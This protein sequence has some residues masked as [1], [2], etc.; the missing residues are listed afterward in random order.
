MLRLLREPLLHFL[1]LGALLFRAY[2][3][4]HGEARTPAK[5]ILV[6]AGQTQS[7]QAQFKRARNRAPTPEETQALVDG[8]V[9]D[10]ILYR[11]GLALGLDRDDSV[12]RRRVA[13]KLEFIVDGATP[14]SPTEAELQAWLDA[15]SQ[16][17]RIE[18][19][20]SLRQIYFDVARHGDGLDAHVAAARG[21]LQ[22]GRM[23]EGD[24][25]LLPP[26]MES[27]GVSQVKRVFGQ[28]FADALEG[29]PVGAWI[30]P[31][32]SAFGVHLVQV[33]ASEAGRTA[34]MTQARAEVERDLLQARTVEAGAAH[35]RRLRA[36]YTVRIDPVGKATH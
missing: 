21:A 5:E 19:R 20:Y 16:L 22:A 13:Q 14:A 33:R 10:E 7:L 11:E 36:Q 28:E 25:T 31:L 27:A 6:S 3:L 17:Y 15:H 24:P 23:A 26:V 12:V 4:L 32:R 8:W 2:G 18:S 34:T 9:R 35:Y 29:L 30:G 1:L